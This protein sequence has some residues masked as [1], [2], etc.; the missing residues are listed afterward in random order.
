MSQLNIS[1]SIINYIFTENSI[2]SNQEDVSSELHL[3]W[4]KVVQ[5][6]IYLFI[7][8]FYFFTQGMPKQLETGF[9][10]G[11]AYITSNEIMLK[12]HTALK[13]ITKSTGTCC[14]LAQYT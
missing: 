7:Y 10:W 9:H 3:V 11:P 1:V 5:L 2:I 8:L 13:L 14:H 4:Y 6:F 12:V